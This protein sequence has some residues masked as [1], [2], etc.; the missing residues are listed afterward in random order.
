MAFQSKVLFTYMA[1][2]NIHEKHKYNASSSPISLGVVEYGMYVNYPSAA[3][4]YE[5]T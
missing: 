4:P 5:P 2:R 3:E 1:W